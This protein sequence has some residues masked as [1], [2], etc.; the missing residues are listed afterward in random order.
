MG[1]ITSVEL[2]L[3]LFETEGSVFE[4]VEDADGTGIADEEDLRDGRELSVM[5]GEARI[6][7]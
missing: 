2:L 7:N 6:S 1:G 4:I 3:E 5:V